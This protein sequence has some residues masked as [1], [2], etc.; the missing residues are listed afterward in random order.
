MYK[1]DGGRVVGVGRR[2]AVNYSYTF[3]VSSC[4]VCDMLWLQLNAI[5]WHYKKY[6]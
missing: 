1:F 6:L 3:A 5:V 4:I 2:G